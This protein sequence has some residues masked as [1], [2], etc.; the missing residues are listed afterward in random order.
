MEVREAPTPPN[1]TEPNRTNER[2]IKLKRKKQTLVK[3]RT[4]IKIKSR[5]WKKNE[6]EEIIG[7]LEYVDV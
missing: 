7:K 6:Q 2:W 4:K 5:E 1:Q 3:W